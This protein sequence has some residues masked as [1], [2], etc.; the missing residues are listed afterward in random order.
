LYIAGLTALGLLVYLM[1]GWSNV[2]WLCF[3]GFWASVMQAHFS[4]LS[5]V[6]YK[7]GSPPLALLIVLGAPAF[8]RAPSL[9]RRLSA[10][11]AER[12]A[13]DPGE[14]GDPRLLWFVTLVSPVLAAVL[15]Q[16][17]L[18]PVPKELW[19]ATLAA[20]GV[21]AF[22]LF[23]RAQPADPELRHV[24]LT[25]AALWSVLGLLLTIRVPECIAVVA[26]G[27]ILILR[28][29]PKEYAGPM[30][31]AKATVV[32]AL[33]WVMSRELSPDPSVIGSWSWGVSGFV[34]ILAGAFLT[35]EMLVDDSRQEG[36]VIGGLTYFAS[37]ILIATVL[38]P[39]WS[40]LVTSGYAV[41]AATL[42]VIG[43]RN[44]QHAFLKKLGAATIVI[45][46]GRVLFVDLSSVETV[47]RVLLFLVVGAVFL[48][49]AYRMQP[50]RF[51][52]S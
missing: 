25:A 34:S 31:V 48:V 21:A 28:V 10:T 43:R 3:F 42:L 20:A 47:W 41:L 38:G 11:G 51:R 9:R 12:Y 15:L 49:T 4:A 18:P 7:I 50:S 30:L 22:L 32:I 39:V 52:R 45:V 37:I 1:R 40:P 16:T 2:A 26:I 13:G 19:G 33:L 36:L 24:Q 46:V 35:R 6:S 17:V 44:E 27:V 8:A 29:F 23:Q 5:I 14:K